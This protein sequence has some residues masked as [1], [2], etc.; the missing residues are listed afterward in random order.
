MELIYLFSSIS[1]N[2]FDFF[3]IKD[4]VEYWRCPE[5]TKTYVEEYSP[6]GISRE[7]LERPYKQLQLRAQ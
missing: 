2:V 3:L 1:G 4:E 7:G 5:Y 6:T